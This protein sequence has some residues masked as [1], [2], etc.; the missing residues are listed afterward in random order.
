MKKVEN[1]TMNSSKVEDSLARVFFHPN[2]EAAINEQISH[3][4]TMS[5]NYDAVSANLTHPCHP[6]SFSALIQKNGG[7]LYLNGNDE[8]VTV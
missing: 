1:A 7:S 3:E 6:P 2:S 4:L 5:Y 8:P